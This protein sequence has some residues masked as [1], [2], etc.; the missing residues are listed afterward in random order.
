M[1]VPTITVFGCPLHSLINLAKSYR[2]ADW[3][4]DNS[5]A[6][7]VAGLLTDV[8]NLKKI[9]HDAYKGADDALRTELQGYADQAEADALSAA[10][11]YTDEAVSAINTVIEEN[12]LT[13]ASAL[14]DLDSRINSLAS[15]T[16]SSVS[17][18]NYVEATTTD[19]AVIVK[20]TTGAVANGD[21]ALALASDVKAYYFK[22]HNL[23]L[24]PF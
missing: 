2:I 20:A 5:H 15:G 17:G 21:N 11:S 4:A 18:E 3:I 22:F 1:L 14:T 8:E 23:K 12:E 10:K 19:G 7:D 6:E 13:V 9:D 24:R 16:V